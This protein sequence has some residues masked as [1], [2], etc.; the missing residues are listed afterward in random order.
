MFSCNAEYGVVIGLVHVAGVLARQARS[1]RCRLSVSSPARN[2]RYR[3][4]LQR[5]RRRQRIRGFHERRRRRSEIL[6][7][8]R[9]HFVL[10]GGQILEI[11][12]NQRAGN[13]DEGQA[14][15]EREAGL[16]RQQP[17]GETAPLRRL[18]RAAA[19]RRCGARCRGDAVS[20]FAMLLPP[21]KV[22]SA[23]GTD[24]QLRIVQEP[25]GT[26]Q[27]VHARGRFTDRSGRFT[28]RKCFCLALTIVVSDP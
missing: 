6:F 5:H 10:V 25:I 18:C 21:S 19:R 15:D 23:K 24:D 4:P 12:G 17:L 27:A 11:G 28:D 7:R 14:L 13:A 3:Q 8:L 26:W 20:S 9:L 16:G 22:A 1:G 2:R